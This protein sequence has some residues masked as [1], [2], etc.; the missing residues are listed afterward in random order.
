MQVDH[1]VK[2]ALAP[3]CWVVRINV[4]ARRGYCLKAG[5]VVD[6]LLRSAPRDPRV[7]VKLE[8]TRRVVT[9]VTNY[10]ALL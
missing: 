6:S 3:L 2:A 1:G 10:A 7:G 9:A 4:Q 5:A 8:L